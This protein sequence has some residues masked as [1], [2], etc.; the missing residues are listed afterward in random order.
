M[1]GKQPKV[2]PKINSP[3]NVKRPNMAWLLIILGAIYFLNFVN[4][5]PIEEIKYGDFYRLLKENPASGAIARVAKIDS[6][7]E[8]E[9]KDKKKFIVL[10]PDNDRD[11]LALLRENVAHFEIKTQPLLMSLL[12][13]LG[14]VLL[15]IFFLVAH[16]SKRR[17]VG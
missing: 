2:K 12:F 5:M 14:P 10:I 15:L 6:R 4:I 11:L 16:G 3:L 8:G 13:S 7:L 17:A 9:L 1:N